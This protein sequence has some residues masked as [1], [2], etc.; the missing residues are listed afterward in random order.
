[1]TDGASLRIS[2]ND[3][4]DT[5]R[6]T[7]VREEGYLDVDEFLRAFEIIDME[8]NNRLNHAPTTPGHAH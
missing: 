4:M 7:E 8:L 1:M 2:R 6:A 5:V 3:I